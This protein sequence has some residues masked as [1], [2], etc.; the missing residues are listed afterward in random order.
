M[1]STKAQRLTPTYAPDSSL[2]V[3]VQP[4]RPNLVAR[5]DVMPVTLGQGETKRVPVKFINTGGSGLRGL[6]LLSSH[7]GSVWVAQKGSPYIYGPAMSNGFSSPL[8]VPN[9]L[10]PTGPVDLPVPGDIL[11]PGESFE[12]DLLV[13]G[14]LT[15]LQELLALFV[16]ESDVGLFRIH[17][18]CDG[19]APR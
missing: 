10:L 2:T 1:H 14:E 4:P 16:Y 11:G 8:S 9:H 7:P 19:R 13:H 3:S 18:Q 6:R 15:G 12:L 5:L 17:S